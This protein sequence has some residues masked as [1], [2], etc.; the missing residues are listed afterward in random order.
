LHFDYSGTSLASPCWAGLIAIANQGRVALGG[1]TLDGTA[2]PR[3]TL[4]ALYSLPAHDFH[5]ITSGYNGVFA[6]TGYDKVTGRGSPVAN[7]L[8]PDLASYDLLPHPQ[9][10]T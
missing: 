3:Q 10:A 8:V 4:E 5:D 7:L 9:N 2:N 6:G 1:K